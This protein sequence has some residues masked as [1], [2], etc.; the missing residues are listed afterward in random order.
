MTITELIELLKKYEFGDATGRPR[1]ISFQYENSFLAEPDIVVESTGDGLLTEITLRL[2]NGDL[3]HDNPEEERVM[4]LRE[5][6]NKCYGDNDH[7]AEI[8]VFNSEEDI[9]EFVP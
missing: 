3:Y 4:T 2:E 7:W 1:T 6:V 9:E 8:L 5:L